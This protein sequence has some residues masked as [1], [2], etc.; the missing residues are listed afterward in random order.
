M[1]NRGRS[2]IKGWATEQN[3]TAHSYHMAPSSWLLD[4]RS[5]GEEIKYGGL[6]PI[7]STARHIM[8]LFAGRTTSSP[9]GTMITLTAEHDWGM[10]HVRK[11][12]VV[13]E[14]AFAHNVCSC[15]PQERYVHEIENSSK[16]WEAG[17]GEI[18]QSACLEL[19][20]YLVLRRLYEDFTRAFYDRFFHEDLWL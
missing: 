13:D 14:H 18:P 11:G 19:S 7:S 17:L 3:I 16:D 20:C 9:R 10:N 8:M 5:L 1:R 6:G 4:R 15:V 2:Y 12:T